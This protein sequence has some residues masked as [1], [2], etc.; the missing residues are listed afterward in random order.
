MKKGL[1]N[2]FSLIKETFTEWNKDKAPRLAA[3]LAYYTAFSI[4]PLL[5]VAI[6]IASAIFSE[7]AVRG[8]L[9]NQI[10]GLV[11]AQAADAIQ[12]MIANSSRDSSGFIASLVGVVILLLGAAGVF[13][14]LQDAL[15]TVW[16]VP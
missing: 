7:E 10:Q 12:E 5:I 6:A 8:Q 4:A 16:G 15:N 11:G 1:G 3:A 13:G 9:D 14:Q 2:L